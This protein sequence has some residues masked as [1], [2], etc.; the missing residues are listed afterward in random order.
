[1]IRYHR[2][3]ETGGGGENISR[4]FQLVIF[5]QTTSNIRANHLIFRQDFCFLS[6]RLLR[7]YYTNI[8]PVFSICGHRG[9]FWHG[10][11]R[12]TSENIR[13]KHFAPYPKRSL[14]RTPMLK[15]LENAVTSIRSPYLSPKANVRRGVTAKDHCVSMHCYDLSK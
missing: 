7:V 6:K 8:I 4:I 1:M 10:K 5:W 11:H 13:A 9:A 15:I 12:C 2:R 14:S 3:I